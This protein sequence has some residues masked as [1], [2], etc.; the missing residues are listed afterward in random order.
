[1]PRRTPRFARRLACLSL[2]LA[3]AATAQ[4]GPKERWITASS[5]P[6]T[7]YSNA[8]PGKTEDILLALEQLRAVLDAMNPVTGH[9]RPT[10]LY[11]FGSQRLA[12]PYFSTPV[13]DDFVH[14]AEYHVG[15]SATHIVLNAGEPPGDVLPWVYRAY[16]GQDL[17]RRF[18]DLPLW[19]RKG[20]G[21]FY[22]TLQVERNGTVR[23]GRPDKVQIEALR[24]I[25]WIPLE[26][27]FGVD[28]DS[29]VM[30]SPHSRRIFEAQAWL[31]THFLMT[32]PADASGT[33]PASAFFAALEAGRTPE[34]ASQR[35]FGLTSR[36][37]ESRLRGY[38]RGAT[39]SYFSLTL[40][41]LPRGGYAFADVSRE[42][43]SLRLGQ[44][45]VRSHRPPP[46]ET[47]ERHLEPLFGDPALA[48]DALAALARL[49]QDSARTEEAGALFTRALAGGPRQ[50]SSFLHY[51]AYL[52][53][54]GGSPAE[55]RG[56]LERA[57]ELDPGLGEA[58]ARLAVTH[59]EGE[60]ADYARHLER[61]LELMPERADL[62]YNLAMARLREGDAAAARRIVA[63]RLRN[64]D[65]RQW[66]ADAEREIARFEAVSTSN[67]ALQSGDIEGALTGLRTA[68]AEATDPAVRAQI[69]GS[70]SRLERD[71]ERGAQ[72]DAY[73]DA[74]A[75]INDG[76]L[77]D[78]ERHLQALLG[79]V[80]DSALRESIEQ[81]LTQ[82]RERR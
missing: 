71:R 63:Q 51:E 30:R 37:L 23:I 16:L 27:F 49:R 80:A 44:H 43:M 73:N 7:I 38:S 81:L 55:R 42:E 62:A 31:L 52:E 68:L 47:I 34:E 2:A 54:S 45:L 32:A 78:A 41:S 53:A 50:A 1:M 35:V 67:R 79:E 36:G 75:L 66:A 24:T 20:L 5:G 65:H 4:P 12:E 76:R 69:E 61:A 56:A 82:L 60:A 64:P 33:R 57:L 39:M 77:D 59:R 74:V 46:I 29:V 6:F 11:A 72:I 58:W 17:L 9:E 10:V 18:P 19:A 15:P 48:G 70:I 26:Q 21:H 40:D 25:N 3:T 14:M 28:R 22:A 8:K 13:R